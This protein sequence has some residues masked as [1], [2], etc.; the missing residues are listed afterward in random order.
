M[1]EVFETLTP[2]G[3]FPA[4]RRL[5][6][7]SNVVG[8][9]LVELAPMPDPTFDAFRHKFRLQRDAGVPVTD[10][11]DRRV[12]S[13]RHSWRRCVARLAA[14]DRVRFGSAPP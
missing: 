9:E 10:D 8:L 2:R 5:C 7:E 1:S 3:A 6:A 14:A 11:A 4:L 12:P 13:A